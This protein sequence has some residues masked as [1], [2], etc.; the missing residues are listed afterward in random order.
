MNSPRHALRQPHKG[1]RGKGEGVFVVPWCG[2]VGGPVLEEHVLGTGPEGLVGSSHELWGG[3]VRSGWEG[4][5]VGQE[6][7]T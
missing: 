7:G 3:N 4:G 6:G 1:V 2:V 5:H